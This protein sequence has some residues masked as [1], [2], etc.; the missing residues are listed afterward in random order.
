MCTR[1]WWERQKERD[2]LE[3]HFVV[4]GWDQNGPYGDWLEECRVNPVGSE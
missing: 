2:Y 4:G 1:S 3:D